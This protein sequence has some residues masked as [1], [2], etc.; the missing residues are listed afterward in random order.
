M[1]ADWWENPDDELPR[2][3]ARDLAAEAIRAAQMTPRGPDPDHVTRIQSILAERRATESLSSDEELAPISPDERARS[4]SLLQ[5]FR[6][7]IGHYVPHSQVAPISFA[8]WAR[9]LGE[10]RTSRRLYLGWAQD[11]LRCLDDDV[12]SARAVGILERDTGTKALV[13]DDDV[14]NISKA[15]FD[16]VLDLLPRLTRSKA[17]P[18]LRDWLIAGLNTGLAPSEWQAVFLE[19]T[20]DPMRP[21]GRIWLHVVNAEGSGPDGAYRSMDISELDAEVLGAI[22]RMAVRGAQWFEKDE[23]QD[24][25]SQCRQLCDNVCAAVLPRRPTGWLRAVRLLFI[26]NA[27]QARDPAEVSALLGHTLVKGPHVEWRKTKPWEDARR[28]TYPIPATA[29]LEIMRDALKFL[30]SRKEIKMLRKRAAVI[31]EERR[32]AARNG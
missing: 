1:L 23:F 8:T 4:G 27:L 28:R 6:H 30:A 20:S 24:R 9:G 3:S 18:W 5:K 13:H 14:R 25:Q 32:Q 17:A 31:R 21:D 2:G 15:H 11:V 29:D 19:T 10:N 12:N 7:E 26:V 16:K 22:K